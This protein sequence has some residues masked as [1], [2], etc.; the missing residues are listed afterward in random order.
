MIFECI[1]VVQVYMVSLNTII[2]CEEMHLPKY[3]YRVKNC[4]DIKNTSQWTRGSK[5]LNCLHDLN[6]TENGNVYHCLASFFRNETVEF[7]GKSRYVTAGY[8][9]VYNYTYEVTREPDVYNCDTF[10]S[11]CPTQSFYSKDVRKYSACIKINQAFGCFVEERNCPKESTYLRITN[12]INDMKTETGPTML[13][14]SPNS[15][16]THTK[17][18]LYVDV[19]IIIGILLFGIIIEIYLINGYTAEKSLDESNLNSRLKNATSTDF[20]NESSVI[21]TKYVQSDPEDS[22]IYLSETNLNSSLKHAKSKRPRKK[23]RQISTR[24]VQ[25]DPEDNEAATSS[26]NLSRKKRRRTRRSVGV[27]KKG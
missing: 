2:S 12:A 10:I 7:C 4:P 25:S 5:R 26:L 1:L 9:P 14:I 17:Y 23:K 20:Q 16:A 6:S 8:C 24:T 27:I 22:G 3:V 15:Y 11:G 13:P 21:Y 18:S 19:M